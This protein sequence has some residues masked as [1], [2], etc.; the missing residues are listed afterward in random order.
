MTTWYVNVELSPS[1]QRKHGGS[2]SWEDCRRF[3]FISA[4]HG[5]TYSRQLEKLMPGDAIYAYA[6]GHGYVGFGRVISPAQM[7]R[8][9]QLADGPLLTHELQGTFLRMDTDDP[10][11]SEYVV[12]IDWSG[13]LRREEAVLKG[14][15]SS[16]N[17]VCA[18]RNPSALRLLR[19]RFQSRNRRGP[20]KKARAKKGQSGGTFADASA[21][22]GMKREAKWFARTR[23]RGL[24][25][26][27]LEQAK[28]VCCVCKTDYSTWLGGNGRRVLQ[29]HHRR[30]L[31]GY[32]IPGEETKKEDL[33][34]VC[35]N[36]HLLLHPDRETVLDVEVVARMLRNDVASRR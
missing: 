31:A 2:R 32:R 27:V 22:E 29:V 34:V 13:T 12:R 5:R 23:N 17:V 33:A 18:L 7:A 8:D 26:H 36:C 21:F 15:S 16:R 20:R 14:I 28:G 35:A 10:E 11:Q 3:G 6:P 1:G 30:Q 19:Q 24:R 25:N 4:G 9:V